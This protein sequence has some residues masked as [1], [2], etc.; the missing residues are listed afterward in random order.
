M[1]SC[2]NPSPTIA[3]PLNDSSFAARCPQGCPRGLACALTAPSRLFAG[4]PSRLC[5]VG[6]S[7]AVSHAPTGMSSMFQTPSATLPPRRRHGC[8]KAGM[9]S[10]LSA[11][12]DDQDAAGLHASQ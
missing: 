6:D 5:A 10:H 8:G 7:P 3:A 2:G 4:P 12:M 11:S 9:R 1:H